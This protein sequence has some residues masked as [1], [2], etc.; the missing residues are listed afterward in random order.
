MVPWSQKVDDTQLPATH[1]SLLGRLFARPVHWLPSSHLLSPSGTGGLLQFPWLQLS[2]VHCLPSLQSFCP[3]AWQPFALQE[4]PT[5][6]RSP[7]HSVVGVVGSIWHALEQQSPFAVLESSHVS[8]TSR[9][10][11]PQSAVSGKRY[12]EPASLAR[13]SSNGAPTAISPT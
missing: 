8:P 1:R 4:S 13:R 7:S 12:A 3:P 9:K 11:S 2:K 10:P 5:V 6:Q